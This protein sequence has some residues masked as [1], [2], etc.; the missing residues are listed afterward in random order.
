MDLKI[1]KDKN[2]LAIAVA[3]KIRNLLVKKPDALISL[4]AGESPMGVFRELI[5]M[6]EAG[7][8]D[9]SSA[10]FAG[11]DEWV[12][13]GKDHPASCVRFMYREFFDR[14]NADPERICYFDGEADDMEK[15]CKRLDEF[16]I[17]HG[18]IDLILLGVGMNGHLG[19]N[20]PGV[21][22]ELYS[23]VIPVSDTTREV[24]FQKYFD[25]PVE[26]TSGIT[27]G[28]KHIRE[29][30]EIIAIMTGRHKSEIA[31]TILQGPVTNA[32]PASLLRIYEHAQFCLD[33]PA[34]E[35]L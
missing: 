20:E 1:F 12:A 19:L 3:G 21:D 29:S 28:M 18:H 14:I 6:N 8:V 13:I 27:L 32:I 30:R 16:I 31:K 4:P 7:E 22:P 26:L 17:S 35:L 23:H 33:S 34:A 10:W 11:L 5:R 25:Q 9:F 2:E 24:A 15:E